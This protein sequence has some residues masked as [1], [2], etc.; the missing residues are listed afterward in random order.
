MSLKKIEKRLQGELQISGIDDSSLCR[1][2]ILVSDSKGFTLRNSYLK[3]HP[4]FNNFPCELWCFSG[5]KTTKLVDLINTRL[6]KAVNRHGVITIYLWSG[7]CDLTSKKDGKI[8]LACCDN[9]VVDSL[10]NKFIEAFA[11]VSEFTNVTLKLLE[12]P[13]YSIVEYNKYNNPSRGTIGQVL[14]NGTVS[15]DDRELHR[16]IQVL[17]EHIHRL[18]RS[19]GND[20][21]RLNNCIIRARGGKKCKR[22]RISINVKLYRDGIHPGDK[23]CDIWSRLIIKDIKATCCIELDDSD[24]E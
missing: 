2:P 23:L 10:N 5:A 3:Q 18:N 20:T 4:E 22:N 8:T 11:I 15:E 21:I 16:Q 9:S 13:Q 19:H 6:P 17:N 1:K 7:T 14:D 24:N 12:C